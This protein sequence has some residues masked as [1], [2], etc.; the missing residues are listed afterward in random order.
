MRKIL[1]LLRGDFNLPEQA[2]LCFTDIRKMPQIPLRTFNVAEPD[3]YD[4]STSRID[5]IGAI[6]DMCDRSSD[7]MRLPPLALARCSFNSENIR[8]GYFQ[9]L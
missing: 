6:S 3:L 1:K 2:I 8:L 7:S 5:S 9:Y 4:F